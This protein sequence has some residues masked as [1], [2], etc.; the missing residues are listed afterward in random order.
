VTAKELRYRLSGIP[1]DAEITFGQLVFNRVKQRG[2]NL[3]DIELWPPV[4]WS[5]DSNE[6]VV[7]GDQPPEASS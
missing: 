1:D 5:T 4:F 7:L 2:A 3:F 6:W